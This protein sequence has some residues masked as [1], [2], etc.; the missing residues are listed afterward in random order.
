MRV[1]TH[2]RT[3][4][5]TNFAAKLAPLYTGPY[6]VA[7]KLSDVNNRLADVTTGQDMKVFHVAN[8][9]PFRTWHSGNVLKK[10]PV[11]PP[12]EFEDDDTLWGGESSW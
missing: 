3:D 5:S 8:K 9:E 2:P 6:R 10:M 1:K 4:S 11:N 12:P 7:Q